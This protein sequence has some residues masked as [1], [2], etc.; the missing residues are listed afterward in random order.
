MSKNRINLKDYSVFIIRSFIPIIIASEDSSI[1][2]NILASMLGLASFKFELDYSIDQCKS[3]PKIDLLDS[4]F[5]IMLLYYLLVS[6]E[7]NDSKSSR[8]INS[9]ISSLCDLGAPLATIS[10]ILLSKFIGDN[11]KSCEK[12]VLASI[13]LTYSDEF[14]LLQANQSNI[15]F[16]RTSKILNINSEKC[17]SSPLNI[18]LTEL[19]TYIS[20]FSMSLASLFT[21]IDISILSSMFGLASFKVSLDYFFG[22]CNTSPNALPPISI[23]TFAIIFVLSVI[24]TD[25]DSIDNHIQDDN[26]LC[27]LGA[28]I[29]TIASIFLSQI[30]SLNLTNDER[31]IVCNILMIISD[32][33]NLISTVTSSNNTPSND[34]SD[35]NINDIDNISN[36]SSSTLDLSYVA[37]CLDNFF[38]ENINIKPKKNDKKIKLKKIIKR[39]KI[40]KKP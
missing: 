40:K 28:P 24:D 32:Q 29:L 7:I 26:I 19:I 23:Q 2:I 13:L 1:N 37:C 5:I 20:S 9:S 8:N 34:T 25:I 17:S 14:Q 27:Y 31:L 39:R 38:N 6:Q 11:I 3:S 35:L 30:I 36:D 12:N 21:Q 10:P 16:A 22:L 33:L 15:P 4:I 18:S